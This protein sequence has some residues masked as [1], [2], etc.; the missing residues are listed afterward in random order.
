MVKRELCKGPMKTRHRRDTTS[1]Q[2]RDLGRPG[3]PCDSAWIPFFI[4]CHNCKALQVSHMLTQID[5]APQPYRNAP[6]GSW[7]QP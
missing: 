5:E 1:A 3:Y 2:S 7:Q 4:L 6:A